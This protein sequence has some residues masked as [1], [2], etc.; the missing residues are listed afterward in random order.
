MGIA[1]CEMFTSSLML[2]W[3]KKIFFGHIL[4]SISGNGE[5]TRSPFILNEVN[6]LHLKFISVVNAI[7]GENTGAVFP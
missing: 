4:Q 1:W 3:D 6:A 5:G 7:P 2:L